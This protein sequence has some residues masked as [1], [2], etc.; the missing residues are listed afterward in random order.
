[1]VDSRVLEAMK[2]RCIGPPRGGRVVAVAGDPVKPAVFYFGACAGGVWKTDDA[3]TYWQNVS[4]G[5]FKTA[6]VGAIAVSESDPNV[7]YAG[8]GE[9]CI[10][11]DVSHGD[12]VYRSTDAGRTWTHLGLND[13]RHI[14]RIRV[15]PQDPD[16]V[17]VGALGHAFGRNDQRGVFRSKDGGKTWDS[18]LS[19]SRDAGIAD[20][21]MDPNNPRI[22]FAAVWQA[23]RTFWEISGG[24]P[25]SGLY[26]SKDGGDTWDDISNSPGMPEGIKGRIGVAV[27]PARPGRVWATVEAKKSG[28]LRSD[29]WGATWETVSDDA[30]LQGRPWYYQH[31]FAD[32]QDPETVW[33]LN[34]QCWRS[35]DGGAT[36]AEVTTPHGDYHDLWIDPRDPQR[37]IVGND[38][39]GSVSFNGGE[40]WSTIYNQPTS[41][42]YHV[43][44]DN[45]FPYRVY[46]TQQDNGAISVP[47]RTFK[48]A[49]PW[50]DCY[51]VGSS[52][53]GYVAVHPEDPN[54][55]Y[56]GAL[57]S[58]PGG[59]APL[60]RYDHRTGQS[61]LVTA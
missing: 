27:S 2:W 11:G 33:V 25:D 39:G 49:I 26:R 48:G 7:V 1:M 20:L 4:D 41:Q 57:G 18:V 53:S 5:Y 44:T 55:V 13:T 31:I 46:G 59:G 52:E 29:D 45:Q 6:A 42:F 14:S 9:A 17:Y 35:V 10:R 60:I 54:I 32:P 23:R 37:M 43:T 36:F 22:L 47:S 30:D 58:A 38:G 61:R 51:G 21:S 56:T 24:G 12:G 8:M 50:T 19:K 3:G 34:Y 40:S 28:I 15:H 16:T